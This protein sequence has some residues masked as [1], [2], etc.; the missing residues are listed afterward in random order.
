ME[1][2]GLFTQISW[3]TF[4]FLAIYEFAG[5]FI[6]LVGVNCA[7]NDAAVA[8]AGFFIAATLTGRVC[9]G[10]FNSAITLAVYITEGKWVRNISICLLIMTIDFCGACAAMGISVAMLGSDKI[11]KLA[12][13]NDING[14]SSVAGILFTESLFTFILVSTVL[15]VKYRKVSATTDG[16]LSNLTCAFAVFVC[17]SMAAP[18][19]GAGLNPTFGLALQVTN[20]II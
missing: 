11:F 16:M 5:T 20:I 14:N 18:I 10:H 4:F 15:F 17:I 7:Q 9:G 6:A 8:A 12:P 3:K 2:E 19:S 1:S 13:P